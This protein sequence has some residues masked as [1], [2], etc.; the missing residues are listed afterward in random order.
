MEKEKQRVIEHQE[1]REIGQY[2]T[3]YTFFHLFHDVEFKLKQKVNRASFE[4]LYRQH[5]VIDPL[6][7]KSLV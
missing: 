5:T 7:S 1:M 4:N 3:W 2:T 6:K